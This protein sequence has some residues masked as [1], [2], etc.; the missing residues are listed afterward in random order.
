MSTNYRVGIIGC[1]NIAER[2]ARGYMSVPGMELVAGTEV[3]PD[4]SRSFQETF[5]IPTMYDDAETMLDEASLDVV[6]ICTWHLLHAPQTTLAARK[7]VK[8]VLC[9]KPMAIG[10]DEADQMIDACRD[11]GTKLAIAHQRRF[12]PGWTEARRLVEK[13]AIGRPVLATGHVIDGM[14]NT[15]SHT[16]DG[17]RYV[18]GDPSAEWVMG[19]L[20]RRSNRWERNVPIEDAC[21][22]LMAFEGGVQCLFQSD[23]TTRNEP[24]QM[25]VQGSDGLIE[26]G[27]DHLRVISHGHNPEPF[28]VSWDTEIETSA[29]DAGLEG[30][31]RVAYAAQARGL[32]AWLDETS[33]YCSEGTQSRH[34]VE[35]MM[36]LY[37]SA[38]NHEIVRLPLNEKGYPL[39][40]MLSEGRISPEFEHKY[41]IRS[42]ERRSWEHWE[43][44]TRLR[45][46]GLSH[47]EIITRIFR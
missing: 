38:R 3:D 24:D 6:S 23:L 10:L 13:G 9:E 2:H 37:Q 22:G 33:S 45:T 46:S 32:K 34:A 44:Y 8:A 18:L 47:P 41:D 25:T 16:V 35:L 30:F 29:N 26:V 1:G 40:Q 21:V 12:Y 19:A 5:S 36:A 14:L 20:E 31:F 15:G 42:H 27:P 4:V 17:I 43:E 7:G 11:S 28:P 39:S